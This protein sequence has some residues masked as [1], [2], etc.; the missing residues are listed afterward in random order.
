MSSLVLI[1]I[2]QLRTKQKKTGPG[3]SQEL[4]CEFGGIYLHDIQKIPPSC[5]LM[6]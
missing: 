4:H 2:N 5:L 6:D 3:Q 1:K